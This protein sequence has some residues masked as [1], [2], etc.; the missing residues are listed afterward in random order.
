MEDPILTLATYF[1]DKHNCVKYDILKLELG[2]IPSWE[3]IAYTAAYKTKRLSASLLIYL[4]RMIKKD[5]MFYHLYRKHMRYNLKENAI[6]ILR[7]F[8]CDCQ[9]LRVFL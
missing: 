5:Q 3:F 1:G 7:Y 2:V 8:L 6:Y 4:K 9:I